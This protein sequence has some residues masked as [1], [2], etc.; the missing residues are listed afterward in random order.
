MQHWSG[1][2]GTGRTDAPE[3]QVPYR[4]IAMSSPF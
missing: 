3:G 1:L 4:F 2:A